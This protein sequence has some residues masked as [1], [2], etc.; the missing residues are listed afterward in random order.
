M[1]LQVDD[2]SGRRAGP[3]SDCGRT[4]RRMDHHHRPP[5]WDHDGNHLPAKCSQVVDRSRRRQQIVDLEG[6]S[7]T[8]EDV[9]A[10]A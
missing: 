9:A 8:T 1:L 2:D 6:P 4:R 5:G 7:S 10:V 3:H